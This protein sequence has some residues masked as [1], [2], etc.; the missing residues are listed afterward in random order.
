MYSAPGARSPVLEILR[1]L[2]LQGEG[3]FEFIEPF[4]DEIAISI[5]EQFA[6]AKKIK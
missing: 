1:W 6:H 2:S 4:K 5:R 3:E